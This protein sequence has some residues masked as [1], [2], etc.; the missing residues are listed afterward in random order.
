M[1]PPL[2]ANGVFKNLYEVEAGK[3]FAGQYPGSPY[4]EEETRRKLGYLLDLGVRH[5]IDLTAPGA[6]APYDPVLRELNAWLNLDAD[7]Q[8]CTILDYTV[9]SIEDM[10]RILDTVDAAVQRGGA[11]YVHCWSGVGR[12][13]MLVGCY[14]ARRGLS[15]VQALARITELRRGLEKDSPESDAQRALVRA[16]QVGQ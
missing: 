13:G 10:I 5:F 15:G 12:T 9:P 3:L 14:L 4:N 11:A 6:A 16:W 2:I 7:Y 8:R 1:L